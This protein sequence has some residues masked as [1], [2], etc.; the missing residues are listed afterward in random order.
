MLITDN[1]KLCGLFGWNIALEWGRKWALERKNSR[2]TSLFFSSLAKSAMNGCLVVG[3]KRILILCESNNSLP[4]ARIVEY[5]RIMRA[6]INHNNY[7][8]F[9]H[10]SRKEKYV[11]ATAYMG[12]PCWQ[13]SF[14]CKRRGVLPF[15]VV[16]KLLVVLR[17]HF[18]LFW[19][20]LHVTVPAPLCFSKCFR[21][22]DELA[23]DSS[24]AKTGFFFQSQVVLR[25]R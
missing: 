24:I 19:Q 23:D 3:V 14:T 8:A 2:K 10:Q 6:W 22:D 15:D 1:K 7:Q 9:A 20:S 13:R 16:P 18:N 5:S 11:K 4:A 12:A 25:M 17:F 21:T